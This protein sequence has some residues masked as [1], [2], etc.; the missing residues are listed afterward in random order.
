M[1]M[2]SI[3]AVAIAA[4]GGTPPPTPDHPAPAPVASPPPADAQSAPDAD[5]YAALDGAPAWVF[6]YDAAGRRE[7]WTLRYGDGRAVLVVETQTG[8]TRYVGTAG[9][10]A[11]IALRVRSST[12][13]LALECKKAQRA[14]GETCNAKRAAKRDVLDC[15]HPDF[16]EPMPFGAAPGIEYA[17]NASCTGY[18]AIAP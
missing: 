1:R 18:R 2:L 6:R 14:I 5:A 16:K 3:F 8:T 4:C 17:A 11:T 12:S 9:D 15:Y 13:K 7:T 10:G